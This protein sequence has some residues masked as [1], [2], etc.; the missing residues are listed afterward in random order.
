MN[1]AA[2]YHSGMYPEIYAPDRFHLRFSFRAA[3][4]DIETCTLVYFHKNHRDETTKEERMSEQ[5]H[6][7]TSVVYVAVVSFQKPARYLQY[8]FRVTG[9]DGDTRWYNAWGTVEKCPDSGFFEYAYANKCF[10]EYMP[11]KWSQG[12]IYYQ[13]FPERFR[14]ENPFYAPENCVAWGSK[15]TAS[16]FMGGNLNGIR[17]SLGYLAELGV[18]CI[19]LNPVFTSP[20]NHKYDTTDYYKVDPHFGINEDLRVLV[21]EAHEKT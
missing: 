3:S 1:L 4:G 13:I 5:Y 6:L 7:G 12:T 2:F 15:P 10:V 9:K 21:K 16:N 11:P 14:K 20:S 18:E 8:Y 19:Y 17:K